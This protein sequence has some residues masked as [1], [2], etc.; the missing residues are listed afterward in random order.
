MK[1]Q[2]LE[3]K[4]VANKGVIRDGLEELAKI[5]RQRRNDCERL[6]LPMPPPDAPLRIRPPDN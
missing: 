6:N 3:E 2:A 1:V 4:I 5:M